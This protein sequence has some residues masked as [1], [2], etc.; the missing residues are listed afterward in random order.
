MK[1]LKIIIRSTLGLFFMLWL[2]SC[3][4][5]V[6]LTPVAVAKNTTETTTGVLAIDYVATVPV[7]KTSTQFDLYVR[8][9]SNTDVNNITYTTNN[10]SVYSKDAQIITSDSLT[11]CANIGAHQS[12]ALTITTPSFDINDTQGSLVL[13][14]S[15]VG[16]NGSIT[17]ISRVINYKLVSKTQSE[18]SLIS[19][20]PMQIDG[21]QNLYQTVFI[22]NPQNISV[23]LSNLSLADGDILKQ[24]LGEI[25]PNSILPLTIELTP[26]QAIQN[27]VIKLNIANPSGI[28]QQ[29][30]QG[31]DV[32][33]SS[34]DVLNVTD[35]AYLVAS[36]PSVVNT[37]VSSIGTFTIQNINTTTNA[38]N[39]NITAND[40]NLAILSGGCSSTLP[41]QAL[42]VESFSVANVSSASGN[43]QITIRYGATDTITVPIYWYNT[44]NG[45]ML[46]IVA[47]QGQIQLNTGDYS[48]ESNVITVKN[49]GGSPITTSGSAFSINNNT[50]QASFTPSNDTCS[51]KTLGIGQTCTIRVIQTDLNIESNQY[52]NFALQGTTNNGN[53]YKRVLSIPYTTKAYHLWKQLQLPMA[54]NYGTFRVGAATNSP[55]P[56]QNSVVFTDNTGK[57]WLFGGGESTGANSRNDLWSYNPTTNYWTWESGPTTAGGSGVYTGSNLYPMA[58]SRATYCSDE[59][60]NLWMYGGHVSGANSLSTLSDLWKYNVSTGKW[61]LLSGNSTTNPTYSYP[62]SYGL[63]GTPASRND[64]SCA[65]RN[66]VFWL[67]GGWVYINSTY[68]YLNDLWTWDTTTSTWI[69]QN[70]G[71]PESPIATPIPP[72]N[73]VG[74]PAIRA[75]SSMAMDSH[76]N[77]WLFGG[78]D[79]TGSTY[80]D[81]WEKLNNSSL[82]T[83]KMESTGQNSIYTGLTPRKP[84]GTAGSRGYAT[85]SWMDSNDHLWIFGGQY[86]TL[87]GASQYNDLWEYNTA[88]SIWT[89]WGGTNNLS[90]NA[91]MVSAGLNVPSISNTPG[92]LNRVV[93][94]IDKSN[95]MYIYSNLSNNQSTDQGLWEFVY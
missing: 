87:I 15:S 13:T 61:T 75:V 25:A 78:R 8:N 80:N 19:D 49:I 17:Q 85:K 39:I 44:A 94:W 46:S 55:G 14:L 51:S 67:F 90:F 11:R 21:E 28:R 1:N 35:K 71:V 42:C 86:T 50:G 66:G 24:N 81:V 3:G 84:G 37:A 63:T 59:S 18:L 56:R 23:N 5:G 45:P 43:A 27:K 73:G 88:S 12:C 6:N 7:I 93:S 47:S 53:T 29:N 30:L 95:N 68:R 36:L 92:A 34:L 4:S 77:I 40:P 70:G 54:L 76:G 65:V 33:T 31:G 91:G 38:I 52:V 16:S 89:W 79:A 22:Y 64:G 32:I 62:L 72:L 20:A 82:W 2:S 10:N 57:M 48:A 9:S 26:K 60:G 74:I 58:R 69:F 83:L 41:S